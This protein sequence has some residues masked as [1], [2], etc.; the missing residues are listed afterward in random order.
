MVYVQWT[1]T[2][3]LFFALR[4]GYGDR[5]VDGAN[6]TASHSWMTNNINIS[7][8]SSVMSSVVYII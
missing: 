6:E 8:T 1:V 7:F 5:R 3:Y 2:F 4:Y